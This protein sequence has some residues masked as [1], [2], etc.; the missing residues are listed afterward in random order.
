MR[1]LRQY[2]V[3]VV[4]MGYVSLLE[5]LFGHWRVLHVPMLYLLVITAVSHVVV[6]HMY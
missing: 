5:Q 4:Q 6:V 1:Q 2:V 3:S